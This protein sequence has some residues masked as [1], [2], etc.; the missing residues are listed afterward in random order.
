MCVPAEQKQ[1]KP[2]ISR[3]L[4]GNSTGSSRE[5]IRERQCF[6]AGFGRAGKG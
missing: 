6:T 5:N 1:Y 3:G 4:E 2:L